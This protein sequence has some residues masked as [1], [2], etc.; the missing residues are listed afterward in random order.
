[1][2]VA[3]TC[4]V[5]LILAILGV[6]VFIF[7]VISVID[8]DE[9]VNESWFLAESQQYVRTGMYVFCFLGLKKSSLFEGTYVHMNVRI[10]L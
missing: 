4:Y 10:I 7:H 6:H 8:D 3:P 9:N 1:M 5:G 2:T